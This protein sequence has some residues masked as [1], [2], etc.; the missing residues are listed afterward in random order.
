[1]S[2]AIPYLLLSLIIVLLSAC[3][4]NTSWENEKVT[5]VSQRLLSDEV[6]AAW[7]VEGG[8]TSGSESEKWIRLEIKKEDGTPIDRFEVNHE[9]LLHLIII[10]KDLSYFNHVHPEYKGNGVFEI[11]NDFP[12]GGEYRV[13]ADFQPEGGDTMSKLEW[14]Q[15]DGQSAKPVPVK[16]D[17]SLNK[18]F[19]GKRVKLTMDQPSAGEETT[20][21]FSFADAA[22]GLPIADLQPYLGAIGHVVILSQDGEQYLHVHAVEGEGTGPDATFETSF[23]T[24]GIY[25]IWGQFQRDNHVFTVSYMVNVM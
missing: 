6:Q 19:D 8:D 14:I 9:K 13:I 18:V 20:L 21:T 5:A 3:G 4:T 7:T 1:M 17:A 10:S 24:S 12:A 16:V 25:K 22:T 11:A 23:P 15:V 2:K